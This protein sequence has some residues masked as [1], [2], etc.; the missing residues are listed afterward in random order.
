MYIQLYIYIRPGIFQGCLSA[1]C[2]VKGW[3]CEPPG[4]VSADAG[5][6]R[7]QEQGVRDGADGPDVS[8]LA[9]TFAAGVVRSRMDSEKIHS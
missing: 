8:V 5:H 1:S 9:G 6:A 2:S 3:H 7:L 4:I